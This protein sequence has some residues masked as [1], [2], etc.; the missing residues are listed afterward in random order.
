MAERNSSPKPNLSDLFLDIATKVCRTEFEVE[1][2][3]ALVAALGPEIH[4]GKWNGGHNRSIFPDSLLLKDLI[5]I[6]DDAGDMVLKQATIGLLNEEVRVSLMP[7]DFLDIDD[8]F[9]RPIYDT[10]VDNY[11]DHRHDLCVPQTIKQQPP[12]GDII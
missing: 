2:V 7:G 6:Q 9:A 12:L 10:F 3:P 5:V 1:M 4:V 8:P 11:T